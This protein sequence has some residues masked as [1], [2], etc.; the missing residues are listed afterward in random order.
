MRITIQLTVAVV[1][2]IVGIFI[3]RITVTNT[4]VKTVENIKADSTEVLPKLKETEIGDQIWMVENL[5]VDT[6]RDGTPIPEAKS[7]EE[8]K[9]AGKDGNP[10]WCY[11]E[12]DPKNGVKYG[13]LYNWYAVNDPRG[14]AP[15][16]LHIPTDAE[17]T[18]LTDYLGGIEKAGT[19]MK[20]KEGWSDGG[21][22]TNSSGFSGLPGGYRL[23]DGAFRNIGKYGS[24]WSSVENS[25]TSAWFRYLG[26]DDGYVNR[27]D[28]MKEVGLSVRCIKDNE[29]VK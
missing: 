10:V 9:K 23:N 26:Y 16:G 19:K 22:G 5:N 7:D 20:S 28:S 24:G 1:I 12:N 21:N 29:P 11:Y 6:F 15:K 27:N 13:K 17:W 3:G 2:L 18:E 8:W 14:L 4:D 25:S